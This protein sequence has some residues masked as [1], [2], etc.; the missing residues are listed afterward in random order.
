MVKTMSLNDLTKHE[1][2]LTPYHHIDPGFI[3][4]RLCFSTFGQAFIKKYEELGTDGHDHMKALA[5][6]HLLVH[7]AL[8]W[9]RDAGISSLG[10]LLA[11]VE[12]GSLFCSTERLE[13]NKDVYTEERIRNRVIPSFDAE[14][15]VFLEYHTSHLV[16]DTGKLVQSR[17]HIVSVIAGIESVTANEIVAHP[18]IMGAPSYDYPINKGLDPKLLWFGWAL[19]EIFP[20]D[21]DQ[22]SRLVQVPGDNDDWINVMREIPET[23]VKK[24]LGEIL[25]DKTKKDWPG[26]QDDH[27]S[28]SLTI[29]EQRST[30]A[31]LLKGPA[32]FREMTPDMLGKRADQIY[33]ISNTPAHLLIVQH[34]HQIGEAVRATLRAF[35]VMPHQPR[36]YCLIDGKD[37]YRILKA[38]GKI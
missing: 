18:I 28:A 31:F 19:Y 3:N 1:R 37:T 38:Y 29:N 6:D 21:I 30:A 16:S 12:V 20:Q 32:D 2:C 9:C 10:Q 5:N 26:E 34:C 4:R 24:Y 33:R 15:D 17:T 35:S 14:V 22:F 11:S 23:D 7:M 36:R 25:G 27:F 13:G 8:V